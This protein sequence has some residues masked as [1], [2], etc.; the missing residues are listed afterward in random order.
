MKRVFFLTGVAALLLAASCA[1]EA[2]DV[3]DASGISPELYASIETQDETKVYVD[4]N[5]R[6]LWNADDRVSVFYRYSYNKQYKFKGQT[7]ANAGSFSEIPNTDLVTGNELDHIYAV[8]P[9]L[10][11]TAVT[12]DGIIQVELPAVQTYALN[13]FGLGM[14][15]MV[16]VT[17]DNNLLF[18]NAV[19]YLMLKVYGDACIQSITL[20]GRNGEL[21]AGPADIEMAPRDLPELTMANGATT[22]VTL[23][24][25][26]GVLIGNDAD[27]YTEFWFTLPPVAFDNGFTVTITDI[28]GKTF[29]KTTNNFLYIDRNELQ[30]MAPLEVNMPH[31]DSENIIFADPSVKEWLVRAFD[32][33]NDGEISYAEAAAVTSAQMEG[34]FNCPLDAVYPNAPQTP[35]QSFNEFRYFTG[36]TAVPSG[37][38]YNC[39]SLESIV[40]PSTVTTICTD[41]FFGCAALKNVSLPA[42]VTDIRYLAFENSGVEEVTLYAT[43]QV[44]IDN[45][46]FAPKSQYASL[47]K[48]TLHTPTPPPI[49]TPSYYGMGPNRARTWYEVD[50]YVPAIAWN[51]Y[52]EAWYD[53]YDEIHPIPSTME[54][55]ITF[56]DPLVKQMLVNSFDTDDDGE[57]SY[58]E[59]YDVMDEDLESFF[60]GT[61]ITTFNELKYFMGLENIPGGMFQNCQSLTS[62]KLPFFI[63]GIGTS[64]FEGCSSMETFTAGFNACQIGYQAF[65]NCTSLQTVTLYGLGLDFVG[66]PFN[67]CD[68]LTTLKIFAVVDPPY[69]YPPVIET[70]HSNFMLPSTCSILVAPFAVNDYKTSSWS[71]FADQISALDSDEWYAYAAFYLPQ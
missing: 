70:A 10:E 48:M 7:G 43:G 9:Y 52:Y 2:V 60:A 55:T 24:C 30:K 45:E 25:G 54:Q 12:N 14:N 18:R 26:N 38:F 23:D 33:N 21:L 64:A 39:S 58:A 40:L 53:L 6:V 27:N 67:Y 29:T 36:V 49:F 44:T 22:S 16:S 41:A 37:C 1:K 34:F 50:F 4:D 59:A 69:I 13:S 31:D 71:P 57:L 47:R 8:Y 32:G 61:S 56:A 62:V 17:D 63:Q 15:T 35:F 19:G 68:A 20:S 11:E 5:L 28:N 42:S 3:I 65:L 46:A 51:D 66:Q